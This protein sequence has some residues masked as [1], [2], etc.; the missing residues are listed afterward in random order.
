MQFNRRHI[1]EEEEDEEDDK[2]LAV[3]R[4]VKEPKE[5]KRKKMKDDDDEDFK[6]VSIDFFLYI[7]NCYSTPVMAPI[8]HDKRG[9]SLVTCLSHGITYSCRQKFIPWHMVCWYEFC[10]VTVW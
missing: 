2:P 5:K 4:K 3:R 9:M 8:R 6:P 1:K 10:Q 7:Y